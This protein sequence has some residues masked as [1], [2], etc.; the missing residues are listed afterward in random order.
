[1]KID[2][3][4][5]WLAQGFLI[6]ALVSGIPIAFEYYPAK[7]FDS[8]QRITH[9]LPYGG[10]LRS[11]H[12]FSSQLLL[13]FIVLHVVVELY[14]YPKKSCRD[15]DFSFGAIAAVVVV[16]LLFSGYVLKA[17]QNGQS[18]ALVSQN[19]LADSRIFKWAVVFFK[20]GAVFYW[21]FFLWHAIILPLF[22]VYPLFLHSKRITARMEFVVVSLALSLLAVFVFKMPYDVPFGMAVGHL[23]G[24]WFFEGVENMLKLN[25]D[26]D[27]AMFA[28][29]FPFVVLFLYKRL[30]RFRF[31]LNLLLFIWMVAYAA[32]SLV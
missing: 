12:Y 3:F 6:I 26:V 10:F 11:L 31:W 32:I 9:I 2:Y 23:S 24:P 16:F 28:G 4:I 22:L 1:M 18:A 14:M 27:L 15:V 8:L 29:F 13:L 25:V 19:M 7:A 5:A 30:C 17:D 20:D 21:R